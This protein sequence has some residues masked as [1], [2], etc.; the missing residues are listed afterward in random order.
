M[1]LRRPG[2]VGSGSWGTALAVLIA[3][4]GTPVLLWGNEPEQIAALRDTRRN[5]TFLPGI[6]I[7]AAVLPTDRMA[8][9]AACD[10]LL[11]VTPSKV[12][13]EVLGRLVAAGAVGERTVLLSCTKGID[14]GTGRR[15][16]ELL[17][18]SFPGRPVAVLSG[19]SHAEEVSRRMPTAVVIGCADAGVAE[20]LQRFVA[21]PW[22]RSY[23]SGD[24]AGIELGG[25][26][27]NIF[28]IGAGICDGLGMGDN[29]KAAFVTRSLAELIRLGVVLGGARE[30]FQG[31]SGIGDL[32]VTC[33][34]RH[35][36]NRGVGERIGRGESLAAIEGSMAMVAE[37]VTTAQGVYEEASR[38]GVAVPII[39][40]IHAILYRGGTPRDALD[41]LLARDLRPEADS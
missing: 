12:V 3:E 21:R 25:A 13:R 26:L 1:I 31:L 4:T 20:A 10:L 2:I 14:V 18:S 5:E 15:M 11:L 38:L 30:T 39:D 24:V 34:S 37:G 8:D 17:A 22:F 33:Y 28:A 29:S 41:G 27:K 19:P 23:S 36:R 40:Q 6:E 9:L 7:P 35:S 16:S 32:I